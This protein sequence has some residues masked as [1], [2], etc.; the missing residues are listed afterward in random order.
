MP[1]RTR[2][3]DKSTAPDCAVTIQSGFSVGASKLSVKLT[4]FCCQFVPFQSH[5]SPNVTPNNPSLPPKSRSEL[6][7]GT[8]V[9]VWPFLAGGICWG[10]RCNQFVPSQTHVSFRA[11]PPKSVIPFRASSYA[12]ACPKRLAGAFV[13][14]R[15]FQLVPVHAQV[16]FV[17]PPP[18][19]PPKRITSCRCLSYAIP[20]RIARGDGLGTGLRLNQFVPFQTHVSSKGLP[21]SYPPKR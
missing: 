11:D 8:K 1:L 6:F 16:S 14:I 7:V 10:V 13:G 19:S 17:E 18:K 9:N 21:E 4:T 12:N 15:T 20:W 2:L 3:V 5:V